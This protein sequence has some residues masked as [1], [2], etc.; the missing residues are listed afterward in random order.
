ML[1][2]QPRLVST[3]V[4]AL[5]QQQHLAPLPALHRPAQ[6]TPQPAPMCVECHKPQKLTRAPSIRPWKVGGQARSNPSF[7]ADCTAAIMAVGA[8]LWTRSAWSNL[9]AHVG[10][11]YPMAASPGSV[12]RRCI[13]AACNKL[14]SSGAQTPRQTSMQGCE[15]CV[16]VPPLK[17]RNAA[18]GVHLLQPLKP[19]GLSLRI[20]SIEYA[21]NLSVSALL[22]S[23]VRFR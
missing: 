9:L 12:R 16:C 18:R 13:Y 5:R 8:D 4:H 6:Q 19:A 2:R 23:A 10:E 15:R 20:W 7:F 3:Y 21:P 22:H 1:R 14:A 11:A 17:R